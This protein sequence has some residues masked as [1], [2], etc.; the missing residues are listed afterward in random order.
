MCVSPYAALLGIIHSCSNSDRKN[1]LWHQQKHKSYVVMWYSIS[2]TIRNLKQMRRAAKNKE[3]KAKPSGAVGPNKYKQFCLLQGL[4]PGKLMCSGTHENVA[5]AE[6]ISFLLIAGNFSHSLFSF[7][8]FRRRP[9]FQGGNALSS[10]PADDVLYQIMRLG[11]PT[12]ALSHVCVYPHGMR[13]LINNLL[14]QQLCVCA[15]KGRFKKR[16]RLRKEEEEEGH[17]V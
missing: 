16:V 11:P 7:I 3:K 2:I 10:F 5:S 6:L 13:Y 14:L 4:L 17:I 9:C 15:S 8:F 1:A 12:T